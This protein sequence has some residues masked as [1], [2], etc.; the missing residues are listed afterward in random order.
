[1]RLAIAAASQPHLGLQSNASVIE[2]TKLL[3]RYDSVM[4][5][6]AG[7][8]KNTSN[9]DEKAGES[10]KHVHDP[11]L[12][13]QR[14]ANSMGS[15][16]TN[17]SS[18]TKQDLDDIIAS[19]TEFKAILPEAVSLLMQ[20]RRQKHAFD[21]ELNE[22]L[23]KLEA[24][25]EA[26]RMVVDNLGNIV[27]ASEVQL[28]AVNT[29]PTNAGSTVSAQSNAS[30]KL[31]NIMNKLIYKNL[32]SGDCRYLFQDC[33]VYLYVRDELLKAKDY[34][35][36]LLEVRKRLPSH[37]LTSLES[38]HSLLDEES[39][40]RVTTKV[41]TNLPTSNVPEIQLVRNPIVQ[42]QLVLFCQ[43]AIYK[44]ALVQLV[45][46]SR[47]GLVPAVAPTLPTSDLLDTESHLSDPFLMLMLKRLLESLQEVNVNFTSAIPQVH[48]QAAMAILKLR[49]LY[50]A[51]DWSS[52]TEVVSET[53]LL[54]NQVLI[55][56]SS[57]VGVRMRSDAEELTDSLGT[58]SKLYPATLLELKQC[59][60]QIE[61]NRLC[62]QISAMISAPAITL[63]QTESDTWQV[64]AH[65][66]QALKSLPDL[67][68]SYADPTVSGILS[69]MIPVG[70]SIGNLRAALS[71]RDVEQTSL[72]LD[73]LQPLCPPSLLPPPFDLAQPGISAELSKTRDLLNLLIAQQELRN[74]LND[75]VASQGF[76]CIVSSSGATG[77]F[78]E[79]SLTK[80]ARTI[81]STRLNNLHKSNRR[82][83]EGGWQLSSSI[84]ALLK[85][86]TKLLTALKAL[87]F[88]TF[89]D[90]SMKVGGGPRSDTINSSMDVGASTE[91][92]AVSYTPNV[93]AVVL[94]ELVEAVPGDYRFPAINAPS[95]EP[96]SSCVDFEPVCRELHIRA[97]YL[98][99]MTVLGSV[100]VHG[101]L[102]T[103]TIVFPVSAG[104]VLA[105][106]Q[107]Q[108]LQMTLKANEVNKAANVSLRTLQA[109]V[110][111][112]I[113]IADICSVASRQ[114]WVKI[115]SLIATYTALS[116]HFPQLCVNKTVML[117][118]PNQADDNEALYSVCLPINVVNCV[119][120]V[121]DFVNHMHEFICAKNALRSELATSRALCA[122]RRQVLEISSGAGGVLMQ[123]PS[124]IL[125][126][127]IS[128]VEIQL[129]LDDLV[130]Y[131]SSDEEAEYLMAL[132]R[133]VISI[134]SIFSSPDSQLDLTPHHLL[135][136][137]AMINQV[138]RQHEVA[139]DNINKTFAGM[140][141]TE[142]VPLVFELADV[143]DLHALFAH[144]TYEHGLHQLLEAAQLDLKSSES[145]LHHDK[146]HMTAAVTRLRQ[147]PDPSPSLLL[148]L[149]TAQA[150]DA[151]R[152]AMDSACDVVA[153]VHRVNTLRG[154]LALCVQNLE[155]QSTGKMLKSLM[156][157]QIEAAERF[158]QSNQKEDQ[159]ISRR[160][161]DPTISEDKNLI[162]KQLQPVVAPS[163]LNDALST[164]LLL[165]TDRA[166][167]DNQV[168]A[169]DTAVNY[170][171]ALSTIR[172]A[173][174]LQPLVW[175]IPSELI[176][177][178][179]HY[180][181]QSGLWAKQVMNGASESGSS[182]LFNTPDPFICLAVNMQLLMQQRDSMQSTVQSY[183]HARDDMYLLEGLFLLH[184]V[185][186]VVSYRHWRASGSNSEFFSRSD[187]VSSTK[188]QLRASIDAKTY[189]DL[190]SPNKFPNHENN[191]SKIYS[192]SDME[193]PLK[194]FLQM[195]NGPSA[196]SFSAEHRRILKLQTEM[197][198]RHYML[199]Q[200]RVVLD[201]VRVLLLAQN[202]DAQLWDRVLPLNSNFSSVDANFSDIQL[203]QHQE[204]VLNTAK[205]SRTELAPATIFG[206]A[207]E[208]PVVPQVLKATIECVNHA[209]GYVHSFSRGMT[210]KCDLQAEA[211]AAASNTALLTMQK[212]VKHW[213]MNIPTETNNVEA[214]LSEALGPRLK[215]YQ[216]IRNMPTMLY[217]SGV[218][219]QV[220][221]AAFVN[222][223]RFSW[224]RWCIVLRDVWCYTSRK[225]S[226]V[227]TDQVASTEVSTGGLLI[228]QA[229]SVETTASDP[230]DTQS[231][232][233]CLEWIIAVE[234]DSMRICADVIDAEFNS[235]PISIAS[236][237]NSVT[238]EITRLLE[239][240]NLSIC[241]I[242]DVGFRH[243][244]H[245][246]EQ[247]RL[248]ADAMKLITAIT[249]A[250]NNGVKDS[251]LGLQ[252]VCMDLIKVLARVLEVLRQTSDDTLSQ[253]LIDARN[254]CA[255]ESITS[256]I[257]A[258]NDYFLNVRD[259]VHCF[260][261]F[262]KSAVRSQQTSEI[263][264]PQEVHM[265][266]S[267]TQVVL[268]EMNS[269]SN[270][271]GGE[272]DKSALLRELLRMWQTGNCN[273]VTQMGL[274]RFAQ[275]QRSFASGDTAMDLPSLLGN[276]PQ[277]WKI[278]DY[279]ALLMLP[280]LMHVYR[281]HLLL[282]E[283]VESMKMESSRVIQD[284]SSD[285]YSDQKT[286]VLR[287]FY[288]MPFLD[289]FSRVSGLFS[290]I[291]HVLLAVYAIMGAP[292][293]LNP[294]VGAAENIAVANQNSKIRAKGSYADLYTQ[295][296]Q[297]LFYSN[298]SD[299]QA[300][301]DRNFASAM[302]QN[303]FALLN[304]S[305]KLAILEFSSAMRAEHL[306]FVNKI[307]I[308][309]HLRNINEHIS[310]EL[311]SKS[312]TNE[313]M[314]T[315]KSLFF[316]LRSW[317][318]EVESC[319]AET[320]TE[321][322]QLLGA[323]SASEFNADSCVRATELHSRA[324][325]LENFAGYIT[326]QKALATK[327]VAE[328]LESRSLGILR[329]SVST[330]LRDDPFKLRIL[331]DDIILFDSSLAHEA[332]MARCVFRNWLH[333]RQLLGVELKGY[334]RAAESFPDAEVVS[335]SCGILRMRNAL[336]GAS[337]QQRELFSEL[338]RILYARM[339]LREFV[340][341]CASVSKSLPVETALLSS[342]P[343]VR[344]V[345]RV[346][347]SACS[348][349]EGSA[350]EISYLAETAVDLHVRFISAYD[351]LA[352]GL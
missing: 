161:L 15:G 198:K 255:M 308:F 332:W 20:V 333:L 243:F 172:A 125:I 196:Q 259:Y 326:K 271:G 32:Q 177:N 164:R 341:A 179:P 103:A 240:L 239:N 127:S 317:L 30:E 118:S 87:Q 33:K 135:P 113:S 85:A 7:L 93:W 100:Q 151:L 23:P 36:V 133:K 349:T 92:E 99:V 171:V 306:R 82:L 102:S 287:H 63:L 114:D 45:Y 236:D 83:R 345:P 145:G 279:R 223:L 338:M 347:F 221:C 344:K 187:E 6:T 260:M 229:F 56:E 286:P 152:R 251:I 201:D 157:E 73:Q 138:E 146:V 28:Q 27:L 22:L 120:N 202:Y 209:R 203:R 160:V 228:A 184:D 29:S 86:S 98:D 288:T 174:L 66:I 310:A 9:D 185:L 137:L 89:S 154:S 301:Q 241:C 50:A 218:L 346:L 130:K 101:G 316:M 64:N 180:L 188:T 105:R 328:G 49:Q 351:Q 183:P 212:A 38:A 155:W 214:T 153:L 247:M 58:L 1:M 263:S 270:V 250:S 148:W 272:S 291:A 42:S 289:A 292:K 104:L 297:G 163:H 262:P 227:I 245:V 76:H 193:K 19:L 3:N 5:F 112:A 69:K 197:L 90:G 162:A 225:P 200:L 95:I 195:V 336:R 8:R 24:S 62:L 139:R 169:I 252:A 194:A 26:E 54:W 275:W 166:V 234:G 2:C 295:M 246:V 315:D 302:P 149:D 265:S 276:S 35:G 282:S 278:W 143:P 327:V 217:K 96:A 350:L 296:I 88:G 208:D 175:E 81:I 210:D 140:N 311:I 235:C 128:A 264:L 231:L 261:E 70:V 61:H 314:D 182:P 11:D 52:L 10:Y 67:Y 191:S 211:L 142:G 134:Y 168:E 141:G 25:L 109:T 48:I 253:S 266:E 280:P 318:A 284:S 238:Q 233:D 285:A 16:L 199:A 337:R 321:L 4:R 331:L 119:L 267:H 298:S 325:L 305:L 21:L 57:A 334:V 132:A 313:F 320:L 123:P 94:R 65:E 192:H 290:D 207:L 230:Y 257:S 340:K 269:D 304:K 55:K 129:A 342:P 165:C 216:M 12:E 31:K 322:A 116:M 307:T 190:R 224:D 237:I 84:L 115:D 281:S 40:P 268:L 319:G 167:R 17:L 242:H 131:Q 156:L 335:S 352:A 220:G 147:L 343:L 309:E 37:L 329:K 226:S 219:K 256:N 303:T 47:N 77:P 170:K 186:S 51:C 300:L 222:A 80:Q 248:D 121:I 41:N 348:V 144:I 122:E 97:M 249:R 254:K 330:M 215:M 312:K 18:Y 273:D 108:I 283:F 124:P 136:I 13:E 75:D 189:S 150:Y 324:L 79:K 294:G 59:K 126:S 204:S 244:E 258:L 213:L 206:L 44:L 39:S 323:E 106:V 178:D 43:H 159:N 274:L 71:R 232:I 158:L 34:Q 14:N 53:E 181:E 205:W 68:A 173:A 60:W 176:S 107:E 277:I 111:L 72:L 293:D 299:E 339:L 91:S 78:D 74:V 46:A 110:N 117:R